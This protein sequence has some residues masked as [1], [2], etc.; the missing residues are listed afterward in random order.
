MGG[1]GV[2]QGYWN[3]P[4]A[5]S[6]H[7]GLLG[8]ASS[9][10]FVIVRPPRRNGWRT[11]N[12]GANAMNKR[13]LS[14]SLLALS[15]CAF[16]ARAHEIDPG[17]RIEV[18]CSPDQAVRMATITRAVG[19]SHYWA[20]R[21]ARQQMFELARQACMNGASVVTFVPPADQRYKPQTI[22]FADVAQ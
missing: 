15:V 10:R 18:T 1:D 13:I 17:G 7:P 5:R 6:C 3:P 9:R 2:P 16:S 22:R 4:D 12:N 19:N 21:S 20:P 11:D 14:I 8:I